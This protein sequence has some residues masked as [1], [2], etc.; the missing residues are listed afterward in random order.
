MGKNLLPPTR[1]CLTMA[2][3]MNSR[4]YMAVG[5]RA[6]VGSLGPLDP[7]GEWRP[8]KQCNIPQPRGIL[9]LLVVDLVEVRR[10]REDR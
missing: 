5:V 2:G 7:L 1:Q 9:G 3:R 10:E 6:F 4:M 8:T